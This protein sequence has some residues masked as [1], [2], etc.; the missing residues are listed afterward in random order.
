MQRSAMA[1]GSARGGSAAAAEGGG[2]TAKKN[3]RV[4]VPGP[5]CLFLFS[6][7]GGG[8]AE[9]GGGGQESPKRAPTN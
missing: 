8:R 1:E 3:Q 7:R 5:F 4:P 2:V 9:G 6:V